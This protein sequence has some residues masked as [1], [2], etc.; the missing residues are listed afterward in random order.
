MLST[1]AKL[2]YGQRSRAEVSAAVS[3]EVVVQKADTAESHVVQT[4]ETDEPWQKRDSFDT[5]IYILLIFVNFVKS[6]RPT[7]P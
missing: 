3:V 7:K 4:Q 6:D 5:K 2:W 1:E